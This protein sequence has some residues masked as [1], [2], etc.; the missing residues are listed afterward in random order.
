M[1]FLE[2]K[3]KISVH[4]LTHYKLVNEI[5]NGM[6]L[7]GSLIL[8]NLIFLKYYKTKPRKSEIYFMK[9]YFLTL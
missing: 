2:N 7:D 6:F 3:S 8:T 5:D 1:K 4:I 9:I